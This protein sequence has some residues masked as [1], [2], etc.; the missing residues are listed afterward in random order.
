[1]KKD[2]LE[3]TE[4]LIIEEDIKVLCISAASFPEDA[5]NAHEKL[6]TIVPFTEE[7]R[8]FGLSRP[9]N[10]I[11]TYKAAAEKLASDEV[12]CTECEG[13]IIKGGTY[14]TI[15]IINYMENINGI[16]K[17]FERLI[18]FTDIDPN[19]YCVEWYLNNE[20]DVKCMVRLEDTN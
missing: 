17:A 20:K 5:L 16:G 8:Y 14:R 10:G 1:M 11:I 7:R 19:G 2:V 15:T 18:S 6:H 13:L 12:N 4:I 9:E 3:S